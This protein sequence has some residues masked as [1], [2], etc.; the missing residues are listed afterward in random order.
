MIVIVIV[1]VMIMLRMAVS[2]RRHSFT[3][4]LALAIYPMG[5]RSI[6]GVSHLI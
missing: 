2:F 6:A 1:I 3:G 5:I 4:W